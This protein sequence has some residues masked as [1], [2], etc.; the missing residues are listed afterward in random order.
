MLVVGVMAILLKTAA[1]VAAEPSE[2]QPLAFLVGEWPASGSGQ[3]GAGS[4]AAV[5]RRDLQDRVILRTN[6]AEYPPAGGKPASRHDDF[7]IIYVGAG[8]NVRADYYDNE[9]HV[10]RYAVHSPAAGQ[11]VFLSEAT[12]SEPRFRLT[13]KLEADGALGGEFEVAPPGTPE[14]FKSYL[15]WRSHKTTDMTK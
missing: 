4:G 1:A 6:Y 15:T 2:L 9:G 12:G 7:M 13:Y 8:G 14:A 5:F 11:A 3:P 10:I